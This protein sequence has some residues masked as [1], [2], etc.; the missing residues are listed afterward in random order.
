MRPT[1]E[2]KEALEILLENSDMPERDAEFLESLNEGLATG[3]VWSTNMC[4]KFDGI[5]ERWM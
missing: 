5:V 4:L 2:D 1:K 3:R